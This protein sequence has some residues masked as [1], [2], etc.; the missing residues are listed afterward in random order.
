[1]RA[2][3]EP[4]VVAVDSSRLV[5]RG[6]WY[7][8]VGG[9]ALGAATGC[10]AF[11]FSTRWIVVNPLNIAVALIAFLLLGGCAGGTAGTF[12]ATLLAPIVGRWLSSTCSH[13]STTERVAL[14]T[15]V[16][17]FAA[18]AGALSFAG[19]LCLVPAI[20]AGGAA[21]HLSVWATQPIEV[22]QS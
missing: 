5:G 2:H 20:Y 9:V 6:I 3:H 1:M 16:G 21:H 14:A 12:G 19:P 4:F 7:G 18:T 10:A 17:A 13:R 11:A 8:A 22:P 15:G